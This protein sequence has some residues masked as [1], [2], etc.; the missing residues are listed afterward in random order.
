[1]KTLKLINIFFCIF[2]LAACSDDKKDIPDI[3]VDIVTEL[4]DFPVIDASTSTTPLQIMI[5]C[6]ILGCALTLTH[7]FGIENRP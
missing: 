6:K 3:P 5:A 7:G 2:F 1:M 4:A